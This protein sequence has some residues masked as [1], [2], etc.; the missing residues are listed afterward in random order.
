MKNTT[1]EDLSEDYI[2]Q[3]IRDVIPKVARVTTEE[4]DTIIIDMINNIKQSLAVSDEEIQKIF[5]NRYF[6][7]EFEGKINHVNKTNLNGNVILAIQGKN[8]NVSMQ[9]HKCHYFTDNV[10][11]RHKAIYMDTPFVMDGILLGTLHNEKSYIIG[12]Y[13]NRVGHRLDLRY[14]LGKEYS[15]NTAVEE[16]IINKKISSILS[17]IN[18]IVKGEF[19]KEQNRLMFMEHGLT[20]SIPLTSVSAGVKM[21]LIIKRLLELGEIKE[22]DVLIFDEPEIHLNPA[23]QLQFAET[24]VLL[25]KEFNLTILLTSHSPYFLYAVEVYS[26][27]HEIEDKLRFYFAESDGDT[28]NV[29]DVSDNVDTIYKQLAAPLQK[30]EDMAYEV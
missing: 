30:L 18:S 27:K 11:I 29:R 8:V 4:E 6:E 20:E 9:D 10:G 24:L 23:L 12:A 26:K 25:Q 21:F 28:S 7:G 15:N 13:S 19:K 1:G 3:I 22:R 5:I 17:M 2:Q 14:R 16:V